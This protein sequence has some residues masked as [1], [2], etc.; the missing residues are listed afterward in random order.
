M[1]VY[2]EAFFESNYPL[3]SEPSDSL[4]AATYNSDWAAMTIY[5]R[6]VFV[7]NVGEMVQTATLDV[8]IRQATDA[9]GTGAKVI[10][11]EA[12]TQLSQAAG[13]G[14]QLVCIEIRSEEMDATNNFDFIGVQLTV[15]NAAVELGWILYGRVPRYMPTPTTNWEEIV[16]V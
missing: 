13:D 15:G 9:A 14:D 11:G 4:A 12:I 3:L 10:A 16:N 2:T 5:H 6:A 8:Q 1:A 7:M